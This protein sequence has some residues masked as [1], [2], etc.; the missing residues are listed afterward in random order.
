MKLPQRL[1]IVPISASLILG[2]TFP[3]LKLNLKAFLEFSRGTWFQMGFRI[4]E[5]I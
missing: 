2:V 4:L 5:F 1:A 3:V